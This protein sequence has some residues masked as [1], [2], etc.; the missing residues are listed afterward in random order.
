MTNTAASN[1]QAANSA[2]E[3]MRAAF[4]MPL[5]LSATPRWE[6]AS[7]WFGFR[8][9]L[10]TLEQDF[11]FNS[12]LFGPIQVPLGFTSDF[13]SVPAVTK[14]LIDDDDPDLLYASIVHDWLYNRRGYIN[15][16]V[17]LTR[18][19]CDGVLGEAMR[20]S[21][22]PGWKVAIVVGAV[23]FGGWRAWNEKPNPK[24]ILT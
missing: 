15:D 8:V 23:R 24:E 14:A 2:V 12:E 1:T 5:L 16:R 17:P 21:G 19:E 3:R 6:I 13:G 18:S 11:I 22:A 7:D 4:P 20:A 10:F 9:Q